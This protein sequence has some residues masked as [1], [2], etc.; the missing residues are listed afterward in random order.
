RCARE[1]HGARAAGASRR[2]LEENVGRRQVTCPR[3]CQYPGGGVPD[4]SSNEQRNDCEQCK[5]ALHATLRSLD[6]F[7]SPATAI[8]LKPTSKP[9]ASSQRGATRHHELLLFR[10]G[11]DYEA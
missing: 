11:A 2:G 6:G 1:L 9:S 10:F 7:S 8:R 4:E 3:R 5:N